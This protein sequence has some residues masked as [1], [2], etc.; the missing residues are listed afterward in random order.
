VYT[1]QDIAKIIHSTTA[2][3]SLV[4]GAS[5]AFVVVVLVANAVVSGVV[6]KVASVVSGT[7][8]TVV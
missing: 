8:V 5:V 6:A 3:S 1:A 2:L 4:C 7:V